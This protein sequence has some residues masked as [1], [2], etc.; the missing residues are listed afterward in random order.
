MSRPPNYP[1]RKEGRKHCKK[2]NKRSGLS[3]TT[4]SSK[5]LACPLFSLFIKTNCDQIFC[6]VTRGISKRSYPKVPRY[7]V[8]VVRYRSRGARRSMR[9]LQMHLYNAG[10]NTTRN[11]KFSAGCRLGWAR[12]TKA[13]PTGQSK[14]MN[15]TGNVRSP[16]H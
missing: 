2:S 5:R 15:T 16:R 4:R 8:A 12:P 11:P 1:T 14:S 7:S 3:S 10:R 6:N 9:T 13:R